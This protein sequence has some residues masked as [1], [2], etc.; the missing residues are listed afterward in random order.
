VPVLFVTNGGARGGAEVVAAGLLR[1]LDT[2]RWRPV[3]APL[4]DGETARG[5]RDAGL[6]VRTFPRARVRELGAWSAT[7][8][9]ITRMA[10]RE[11]VQLVYA[12]ENATLLVATAVAAAL[13]AP[14]VWHVHDP[15]GGPSR[16]ER[17]ARWALRASRPGL[18]VCANPVVAA[19]L[20]ERLHRAGR[21]LVALPGVDGGAGAGGDGARARARLGIG[22]E[23]LLAVCLARY[24]PAK[25]Q[26]DLLHAL[27]GLDRSPGLTVALCGPSH[28]A[29][30]AYEA[31]LA[32]TV[33]ASGLRAVV[34][35]LGYVSDGERADLLAGADLLV[36]PARSENFGLAV[37]EAM[38]AGLP[39]VAADA[40][41]PRSLVDDPRTG[42]LYP[43]GDAS[44]L[45]AQLER[46]LSD[47]TWRRD[48]GSA[49][50]AAVAAL[51]WQRMADQI[52][53][54]LARLA[55]GQI[56]AAGNGP[57]K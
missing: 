32:R 34:R 17:A 16:A 20:P 47:P 30:R 49:G 31:E 38:A 12:N 43:A 3:V 33:E 1:H 21:T 26:L 40:A 7:L 4:E 13:R 2:A 22:P 45:R 55:A 51:S 18:V 54:A 39:V 46:A 25:G 53:A 56:P 57:A 35:L 41:G 28:P 24:V 23:A 44:A 14:L 52:D 8:L 42:L 36:H 11:A 15:L 50:R 48:A 10:R 27:S 5:L 29:H 6:D 37:A 9:R 19:S